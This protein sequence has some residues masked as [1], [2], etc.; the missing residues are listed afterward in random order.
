MPTA[1]SWYVRL[2]GSSDNIAA[3]KGISQT[4]DSHLTRLT[5]G[6][7]SLHRNLRLVPQVTQ[8]P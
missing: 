5:V 8:V 4:L 7:L 2:D 1:P 3:F 6:L